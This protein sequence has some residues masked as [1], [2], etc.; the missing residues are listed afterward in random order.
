MKLAFI[1]KLMSPEIHRERKRHYMSVELMMNLL[2][3]ITVIIRRLLAFL[4]EY[5]IIL[6]M[7]LTANKLNFL[8]L[9]TFFKYF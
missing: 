4:T 6:F 5:S 8:K 2:I 1:F 7:T 3:V 9:L